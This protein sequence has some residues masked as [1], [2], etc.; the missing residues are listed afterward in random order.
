MGTST[1]TD[2]G[3]APAGSNTK[4]KILGESVTLPYNGNLFTADDGSVWKANNGI[5]LPYDS[6]YAPF[7]AQCPIAGTSAV[8]FNG[9][10]ASGFWEALSVRIVG[11]AAGVW[12]A[13]SNTTS[14]YYWY[15]ADQGTTWVQ[16]A[17]PVAGKNWV[18]LWDGVNFVLYAAGST[19]NG[20][21]ESTDG[22]AWT[23]HTAVS[24]TSIADFTFANSL[25][26][27]TPSNG[28]TGASSADRTT[29]ASK[30]LTSTQSITA[31]VGGGITSYNAGAAL[32][33][34]NVNGTGQY[35][36]SAD[37]TTWVTRL[38]LQTNQSFY[39]SVNPLLFVS[40]ATKTVA[41]GFG[42][43]V[44]VTA[45][46]INWTFSQI[47]SSFYAAQTACSIAYHDGTRF[48][49]VYA[50]RVYYSTT[51]LAGSWVHVAGAH[52]GAL[53]V[54]RSPRGVIGSNV[55]PQKYIEL[56]DPTSTTVANI[57]LPSQPSADAST[58]SYT[59]VK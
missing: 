27:V 6:S 28:T 9:P 48:V 49:C 18:P 15:T 3:G 33:V 25:Y 40:N 4:S 21:Q 55:N 43:T 56:T 45:D 30:T 36:T 58:R 1:V 46:C 19:T 53:T 37:F 51:G 32:W 47:D 52:I 31:N 59:R 14:E 20:V 50:G 5:L 35:Q 29:W 2:A 41:F 42:G 24:V 17:L 34:T 12:I 38:G 11:A 16:Y 44:A 23:G 7:I 8:Q 57:L 22:I 26:T 39:S 10:F 54:T 13:V